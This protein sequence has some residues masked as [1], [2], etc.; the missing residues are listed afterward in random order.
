MLLA[1]ANGAY[2]MLP[3]YSAKLKLHQPAHYRICIQ[4]VLAENW[5]DY[6]AGL[7]ITYDST[8]Q[9]YPVTILTGSMSDQAMLLGI[10]NSLYG[11]GLPLVAVEWVQ[12]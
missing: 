6:F 4:G 2:L 11:F 1:K 9:P 12:L 7:T 10:L 3:P 8:S 5:S